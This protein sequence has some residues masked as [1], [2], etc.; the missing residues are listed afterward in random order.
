[1]SVSPGMKGEI[2]DGDGPRSLCSR[3]RPPVECAWFVLSANR[4]FG[5]RNQREKTARSGKDGRAM[6]TMKWR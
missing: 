5:G 1:M 6:E 2:D 4:G 3:G